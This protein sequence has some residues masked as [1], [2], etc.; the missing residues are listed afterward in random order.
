M[1]ADDESHRGKIVAVVVHVERRHR[2]DE[3]HDDLACDER[4]DRGEHRR[5]PQDLHER[6]PGSIPLKGRPRCIGE[7]I[8]IGTQEHEREGRGGTHEDHREEVGA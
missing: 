1:P 4:D 8:R 2:H 6:D 5:A 7:F 3:D